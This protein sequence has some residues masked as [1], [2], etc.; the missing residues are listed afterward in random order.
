MPGQNLNDVDLETRKDIVARIAN[1]VAHLG[2]IPGDQRQ[3]GPAG[4]GE[5]QGC[6]WGDYGAKTVFNS[7]EGLNTYMNRRLELRNVSIELMPHPLVL[8][9][10]AFCRRN[11]ILKDDGVTLCLVDW[12]FA[13]FYPRFFEVAV[14]PCMMACDAPYEKPLLEEID[15]VIDITDEEKRLIKLIG[16]VCTANLRWSL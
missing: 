3:P 7:V 2:Q 5:P 10:L 8:C 12:G 16:C 13:G 1:I 11:F 4:G 9:H 6:L 14:I 15:K